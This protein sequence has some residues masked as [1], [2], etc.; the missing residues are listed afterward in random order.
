MKICPRCSRQNADDAAYCFGCG[1]CFNASENR[2]NENPAQPPANPQ[3]G[4]GQGY[5]QNCNQPYPGYQNYPGYYAEQNQTEKPG[6][7]QKR[8][9][10]V[11]LSILTMIFGVTVMGVIALI[12]T[13]K[14]ASAV[15]KAQE[16][17]YIK[18]ATILGAIGLPVGLILN[19]A[20]FVFY[21]YIMQNSG[22]FVGFM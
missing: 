7:G 21:Y 10:L 4:Y 16:K 18:A 13:N 8:G 11:A 6:S 5:N 19:I 22:S 2:Q 3:Q 14:A 20:Y 12:M 9:G 17:G 15:T 1:F